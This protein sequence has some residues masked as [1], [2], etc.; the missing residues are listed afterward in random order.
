MAR[1]DHYTAFFFG[2]NEKTVQG[3]IHLV[4]VS[5]IQIAT[6]VSV[7]HDRIS[8][9]HNMSKSVTDR[10]LGGSGCVKDCDLFGTELNDIALYQKLVRR[11][12][13]VVFLE[14]IEKSIFMCY[15]ID[16]YNVT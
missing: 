10:A 14:N 15:T 6:S 9:K 5:R 12:E 3:E 2:H 8:R 11:A 16:C 13:I 1:V 7:C 4:S